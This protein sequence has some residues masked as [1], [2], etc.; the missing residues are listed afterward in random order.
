M[1]AMY[2]SLMLNSNDERCRPSERRLKLACALIQVALLEQ[3]QKLLINKKPYTGILKIAFFSEILAA[4]VDARSPLI[5]HIIATV[6]KLEYKN[7][8]QTKQGFY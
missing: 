3:K 2:E 6:H 5:T 8:V 1:C 4:P 7:G